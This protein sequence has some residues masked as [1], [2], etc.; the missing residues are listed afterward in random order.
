MPLK[1]PKVERISFSNTNLR[2]DLLKNSFL[3]FERIHMKKSGKSRLMKIS[4][5]LIVHLEGLEGR[6]SVGDYRPDFLVKPV[7]ID[8]LQVR[9]IN[10]YHAK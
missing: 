6:S 9:R 3:F 5:V 4:S 7:H 2:F 1:H 10:L 8:L